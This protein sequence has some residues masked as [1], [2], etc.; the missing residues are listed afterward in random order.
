LL[1][2]HGSAIV[3]ATPNEA[4]PARGPYTS[5]VPLAWRY[6]GVKG[7]QYWQ[8]PVQRDLLVRLNGRKVYWATRAEIPGG[9]AFENFEPEAP[10]HA[11]QEFRFGVVPETPA[12]L[13]FGPNGHK[14]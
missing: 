5:A 11:G 8:A 2:V 13:G 12:Q 10:F 3:A 6:E 14:P 4:D 1:T 9:V 7:T